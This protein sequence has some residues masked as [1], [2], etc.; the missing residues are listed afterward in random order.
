M[1]ADVAAGPLRLSMHMLAKHWS[2]CCTRLFLFLTFLHIHSSG[3]VSNLLLVTTP[4]ALFD[5]WY[6][7]R[8]PCD[9]HSGILNVKAFH[10]YGFKYVRYNKVYVWVCWGFVH[11]AVR[12]PTGLRAM[13]TRRSR[14][15]KLI[16]EVSGDNHEK[17]QWKLGST[18]TYHCSPC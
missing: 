13:K 12:V 15:N 11:T 5:F 18:P 7:C 9:G 16:L 17:S 3:G 4:S 8:I 6:H 14:R 10:T 2:Y 1:G